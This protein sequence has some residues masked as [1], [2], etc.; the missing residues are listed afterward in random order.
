VLIANCGP[1]PRNPGCHNRDKKEGVQEGGQALDGRLESAAATHP[2]PDARRNREPAAREAIKL[3]QRPPA[4]QFLAD[5]D[6]ILKGE[7]F[8]DEKTYYID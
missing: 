7:E 4:D 8:P 5:N 6:Q 1:I 3:T 2:V